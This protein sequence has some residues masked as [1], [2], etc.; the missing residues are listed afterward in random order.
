M[1]NIMDF[2]SAALHG[3]ALSRLSSQM[4]ESP[5]VTRRGLE[6]AVPAAFAALASYGS[7]SGKAEELVGA[8]RS[9]NYPHVDLDQVTSA[10]TDREAIA[11][12]AQSSSGF[13]NRIFGNRLD[14]TIDALAGTSGL[15]RNSASTLLGLATPLVMGFVGKQVTSGNLDARGLGGWLAEQGRKAVSLLPG[16]L[17]SALGATTALGG[18]VR[19]A[20]GDTANQVR[21]GTADVVHGGY[22][23]VEPRAR[24][25]GWFWWVLG[26]LAI[27][28][29]AWQMLRDTRNRQTR[30][31]EAPRVMQDTT[32][33]RQPAIAP[34][35]APD[36]MAAAAA[37]G[38]AAVHAVLSGDTALP[39][40][41]PLDDVHFA[42]GSSAILNKESLDDIT[43][44]LKTHEGARVRLE[45]YADATG[46]SN[47]NQRLAQSRAQAVKDYMVAGG[48]P[49]G[50]IETVGRAANR[51]VASNDSASGRADNR[52]VELTVLDR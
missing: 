29:F 19:G 21:S 49:A 12:I 41:V 23:R 20:M 6:T 4:N 10:A 31:E 3:D 35:A 25:K 38:A 52:R 26:A 51:P 14:G 30:T 47:V 22:G 33:P 43:T 34:R 13:L 1:E 42:S 40:T 28:L 46:S 9:G 8:I 45:G 15:G 48:V 16:P 36:Q 7:S 11:R 27:A 5:G 17:A 39:A 32:H 44:A 2:M 18:N 50:S 24:S 37:T